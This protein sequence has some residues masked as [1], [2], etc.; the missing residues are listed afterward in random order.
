MPIPVTCPNCRRDFNAP[1]DAAGKRARCQSCGA[2][3]EIPGE[4]QASNVAAPKTAL[5]DEILDAEPIDAG[6]AIEHVEARRPCPMCGEMIRTTAVKC[7]YCG[8]ILDKVLAEAARA[9]GAVGAFGESIEEAAKRLIAEKYDRTTAIQIF[10][11]SL[12][13]CFSPILAVYGIVF[14]LR[15]PHSF[16]HKG[17]AIAGT[18]IHCLWTL[19]L[20]VGIISASLK[21]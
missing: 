4:R 14:L 21:P 12:L 1:D 7:R 17:L 6:L 18:I 16:P 8:T 11:L 13:G 9:S 20:A 15:R 5:E 3:I 2:Q 10:V 19:L